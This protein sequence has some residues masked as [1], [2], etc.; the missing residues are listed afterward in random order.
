MTSAHPVR[1][2]RV[3]V[4]LLG[5]ALGPLTTPAVA[6]PTRVCN[7]VT[8]ARGDAA[9]VPGVPDPADLVAAPLDIVSADIASNAR[10]VTV[11][12]RVADLGQ[13]SLLA[14]QHASLAGEGRM[15]SF[16][17][18][19]EGGVTWVFS[20]GLDA[21]APPSAV[22]GS[23]SIGR[24]LG[25]ADAFGNGWGSGFS[26]DASVPASVVVD[27]PHD[28]LRITITQKQAREL[29]KLPSR[30]GSFVVTTYRSGRAAPVNTGY[31]HDY[32][33]GSRFYRLGQASCVPIG[34]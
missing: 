18:D 31:Q 32:A 27:V 19:V 14:A 6:T 34:R 4:V 1:G 12:I 29:G 25:G 24:S 3:C 10:H 20:A 28:Q 30:I 15:Y 11:A 13:A 16:R 17:F 5:L 8:D 7:L 21:A 33:R 9:V 22:Y 2:S 26:N 23:A